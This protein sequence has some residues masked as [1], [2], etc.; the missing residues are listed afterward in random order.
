MIRRASLISIATALAATGFAS[1]P[2]LAQSGTLTL[3]Q[4]E[5][6]YPDM[7]PVH[8]RKCDPSGAGVY[9]H[10]AQL[11]V[12]SIYRTMYRSD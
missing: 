11:C 12:A 5:R 8:I 9:D 10:T 7:S 1:G 2:V 6:E 3:Q 4:L